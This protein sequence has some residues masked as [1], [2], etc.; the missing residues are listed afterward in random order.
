MNKYL[1]ALV[2][3]PLF[4]CT[5]FVLPTQDGNFITGRSMDFSAIFNNLEFHIQPRGE[6]LT[7]GTE[8]QPQAMS[9]TSSYGYLAI[10]SQPNMIFDG[11]NEKG[12]STAVLWLSEG[13]YPDINFE[14]PKPILSFLDLPRW[15]LGNFAL[16][17]EVKRAMQGVQIYAFSLPLFQGI[18]PI[19][20]SIHDAEGKSLVIEF[21][22]GQIVVSDNPVG[23]V[24][25]DPNFAWHLTNLD[26][27]INLSAKNASSHVL[28]DLLV[29]PTGSGSGL[30]GLPGDWTP[31]SRF[32]RTVLMKYMSQV[33]KDR[34]GGIVLTNHLLN[35][36]DLP[37]GLV[38]NSAAEPE[39]YTQWIVI[40]DLKNKQVYYRAYNN[41]N[42]QK[43]DL[44]AQSLHKGAKPQSIQIPLQEVV[45]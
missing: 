32:V 28:G 20:L 13:Q 17:D 30:L 38:R 37:Y 5:D 19:H 27:Y 26:N 12:L 33:P 15:I 41:L 10:M 24:T 21:L 3:C 45:P 25:N 42:I 43:L 2:I 6:R 39:D 14:S 7:S 29:Q 35:A 34:S 40:K 31:P 4:A 18:P 44:L 36:V 1:L 23:V 11:L 16:V 9:W 8:E 22:Q